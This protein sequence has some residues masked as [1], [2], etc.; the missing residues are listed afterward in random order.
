MTAGIILVLAILLLGS[1]IA[2]ISDKIGTKVGKYNTF[3][4][5]NVQLSLAIVA[6][7]N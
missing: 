4:Q 7:C 1:V 5:T 6:D 2:T 3:Y